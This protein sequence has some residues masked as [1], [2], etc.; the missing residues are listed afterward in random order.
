MTFREREPDY[1]TMCEET[2]DTAHACDNCGRPCE[3]KEIDD[4]INAGEAGW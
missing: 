4:S 1:D 2:D 3:L